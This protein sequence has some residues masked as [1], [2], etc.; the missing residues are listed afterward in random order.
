MKLISV[1]ISLRTLTK[2]LI[3][4][5]THRLINSKVILYSLGLYLKTYYDRNKFLI[6]ALDFVMRFPNSF[7]CP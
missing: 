1:K 5:R 4:F 3:N 2:L 6:Q 7:G